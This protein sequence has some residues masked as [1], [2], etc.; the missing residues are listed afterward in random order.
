VFRWF[1]FA[2]NTL[3]SPLEKLNHG[4][5]ELADKV[6]YTTW[7]V[8]RKKSTAWAKILS[9]RSFLFFICDNK[10]GACKGL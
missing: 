8:L 10:K 4:N 5:T 1:F 2:I 7:T 3:V 9:R 6:E